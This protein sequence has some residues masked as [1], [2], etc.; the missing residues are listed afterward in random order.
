MNGSA[1]FAGVVTVAQSLAAESGQTHTL[2]INVTDLCQRAESQLTIIVI[3]PTTTT[4]TTTTT[5]TV[6]MSFYLLSILN[7]P[8]YYVNVPVLT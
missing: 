4:S 5:T 3:G 6:V 7:S 8:S 2:T 1:P